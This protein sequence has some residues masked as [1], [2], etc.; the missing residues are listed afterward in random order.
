MNVAYCFSI[1]R[2]CRQTKKLLFVSFAGL[3]LVVSPNHSFK[4]DGFAAA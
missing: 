2:Y 4:A 3:L 1:V